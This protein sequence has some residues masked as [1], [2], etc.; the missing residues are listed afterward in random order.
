MVRDDDLQK[1]EA[2]E[3]L[4]LFDLS[5]S[6]LETADSAE[7]KKEE[8]DADIIE[9]LDIVEKGNIDFQEDEGETLSLFDDLQEDME[10]KSDEDINLF[11]APEEEFNLERLEET[12]STGEIDKDNLEFLRK[13]E[14]FNRPVAFPEGIFED[15]DDPS[16]LQEPPT[17]EIVMRGEETGIEDLLDAA[18]EEPPLPIIEDA[19]QEISFS[20]DLEAQASLMET[21]EEPPDIVFEEEK[22]DETPVTL[23]DIPEEK[24]PPIQ[25][26]P[27]AA[28]LPGISEERIEALIRQVVEEV[29]ERV[30]RETMASVAERVAGETMA[31]VAERMITDAINALKK[32]IDTT[33]D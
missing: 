15:T 2:E 20:D 16:D 6:D 30:V 24:E 19:G 11:D 33:L 29:L 23:E 21:A 18:V 4:D 31:S 9:L 28:Q 10:L 27:P 14:A 22:A 3:D 1:K 13:N 17:K 25:P 32:S 26:P 8:P 5:L 12:I 7:P